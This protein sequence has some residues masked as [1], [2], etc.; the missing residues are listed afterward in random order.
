MEPQTGEK[1]GPPPFVARMSQMINDA[2]LCLCVSLGHRLKLFDRL[3]QLPP[4][5][6]AQIAEAAGLNERYVREWLSAL[7]VGGI[8]EYQPPTQTEEEGKFSLPQ[9][10]AAFLTTAAKPNDFSVVTQFLPLLGSVEKDILE[11][12][13]HGGGVPYTR[14]QGFHETMAEMSGQSTIPLLFKF[15]LP[16]AKGLAERLQ[17]GITVLD[18]GCGA[19][20][21]LLE[22]AEA[23][24]QSTFVGYDFCADAIEMARKEAERR[25]FSNKNVHFEVQDVTQLREGDENRFDLITAFDAIHDQVHPKLVLKAI[26]AALKPRG[27]FLVQDINASSELQKNREHP[28]G[29]F[30]YTIS[31]MHCMTVSLAGGGEGL[32]TMWGVEKAVKMFREAGFEE[33]QVH[34]HPRSSMDVWFVMTKE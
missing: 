5:S 8:I 26:N 28:L 27:T 21:V 13:K 15:T 31:L 34:R 9:Q 1:Q 18:I 17:S 7:V 25:G 22:M 24:P 3:S 29:P 32:G 11:V 6:S 16:L 20:R 12:M 30:L 10:H 4:S 33:P 14:F 23:Y 19:G 2:A